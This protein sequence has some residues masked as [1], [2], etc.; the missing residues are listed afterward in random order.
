MNQMLSEST[1]CVN[2]VEA[3]KIKNMLWDTQSTPPVASSLF[4]SIAEFLGMVKSKENPVSL[5]IQD[6]HNTTK[7]AGIVSYCAPE[8]E[9]QAGEWELVFTFKEEDLKDVPQ[10]YTIHDS[11]FQNVASSASFKETGLQFSQSCFIVDMFSEMAEEIYKWLDIN[12][13][14][15]EQ[16][17]LVHDGYF[18]AV[19]GFEDGHKVFGITPSEEMK[20]KVKSDATEKTI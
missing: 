12:A 7:L 9:D 2:Y 5:E 3:L 14:E 19:V 1:I 15:T 11:F 13:K 18:T 20:Q 10:R 16:V 8:E 4:V 6:Y 17:E